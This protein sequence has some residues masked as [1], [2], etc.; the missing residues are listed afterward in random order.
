MD[1]NR[2]SLPS[3][4]LISYL[5]LLLPELLLQLLFLR[6]HR[7]SMCC[8]NPLHLH[9]P[10]LLQVLNFL[11]FIQILLI[12][13]FFLPLLL[14]HLLPV[15]VPLHRTLRLKRL[16]LPHGLYPLHSYLLF[17]FSF[18]VLLVKLAVENSALSCHI[19]TELTLF[20]LAEISYW[21]AI[22]EV[23]LLELADEIRFAVVILVFFRW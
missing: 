13:H 4:L 6:R 20:L 23:G 15:M 8:A 1:C 5:S 18:V 11:D 17:I 14:H 2:A 3:I 10:L 19:R 21:L 22:E 9:L 16:L 12:L 7:I